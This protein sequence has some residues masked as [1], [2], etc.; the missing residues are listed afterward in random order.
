MSTEAATYRFSPPA[1]LARTNEGRVMVCLF[2]ASL[3]AQLL[4]HNGGLSGLDGET[5][6]QVARSLVDHQRLDVG[7]GFNSVTGLGGRQYAKSNFGLPLL[8]SAV[9]LVSAPVSWITPEHSAF[10]RTALV[11]AS[12]T[13][14]MSALIVAMYLLARILGASPSSAVVVGIGA[15]AGTYVLPYSKEFFAEPLSALAIVLAIERTLASQPLAA[16]TGL[17]V[18]V[19]SRAQYLLVSPVV[20]LVIWR[21]CGPKAAMTAAW[22]VGISLVLTGAYNAARF[23]DPLAF[24]YPSEGF[25]MPFL[26]GAHMLLVEPSK[27][28][29]VFAPVAAL[30]PWAF[31]RLWQ[32]NRDA[33][34]LI[35]TTL[36][37]TFGLTALWH[38]PNGGWCWGPRLLIPGVMPALAAL[39]PWIDTPRNRKLAI[40]LFVVGFAVS[41]PAVAV[42]TQIQQLDVPSPAGGVWPP[43]MGLPTVGRQAELV[44]AAAAYT[45]NHLYE[46]RSDGRNYLRYLTFWQF[47]VARVF[48]RSGLTA[49]L[50]ASLVLI[51]IA[52]FAGAGCRTA[53]HE[54][55]RT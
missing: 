52:V 27:S 38:N 42:S 19:L 54:L 37:I 30:V 22:P 33:L 45:I 6:Y 41:A 11:G 51:A 2:V 29:F 31:M 49:A 16:G 26:R 24:G 23:G 50:A 15:V 9:Y 46:R 17:A 28:L 55:S 53:C 13:V 14:V 8:A 35:G 18:A 3:C 34:F 40:V 20:I 1:V 43:D 25:T 12:M 36:A 32:Q 4:L 10:I 21:R 47:G 7:D 5:Y 48:G 44:P 39:G